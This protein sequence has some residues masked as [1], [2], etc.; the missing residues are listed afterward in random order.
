MFLN[1]ELCDCSADGFC[2]LWNS[3]WGLGQAFGMSERILQGIYKMTCAFPHRVTI[4]Y[5]WRI[6]ESK[7]QIGELNILDQGFLD[8]FNWK[9]YLNVCN[10]IAYL[11]KP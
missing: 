9:R 11:F 5:C 3:P 6:S 2:Y 7:R 10:N 1:L 8:P 4:N